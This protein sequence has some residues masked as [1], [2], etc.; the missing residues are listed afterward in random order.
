MP[1][2]ALATGREGTA[3]EGLRLKFLNYQ[4]ENRLSDFWPKAFEEFFELCPLAQPT[5]Q[6]V[7][8]HGS[9]EAATSALAVKKRQVSEA[10]CSIDIEPQRLTANIR[11]AF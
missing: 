9:I 6:E 3:L 8:T 2:S 4:A 10:S 1:R 7:Q 11:L 5:E